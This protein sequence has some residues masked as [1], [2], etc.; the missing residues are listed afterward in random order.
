[1]FAA[2]GAW[3]VSVILSRVSGDFISRVM[4]ML[5]RSADGAVRLEEIRAG[6]AAALA[7]EDTQRIL[8]V[9]AAQNGRQAGKMNWPIFWIIILVMLGAPALSIWSVTLYNILWWENGLWP[10]V[11]RDGSGRLVGWLIADYPP[12]IKPWV[13]MSIEW[14]YD[15]MGAPTGIGAA[16][17]AGKLTSKR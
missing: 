12:S 13:Q 16:L 14:L 6:S 4:G 5:G 8:A 3:L 11:A 17:I 9:I 10:Q 1:M 7:R 15:P 2:A